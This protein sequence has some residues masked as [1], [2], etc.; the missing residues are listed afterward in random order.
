MYYLLGIGHIVIILILIS[1][2]LITIPVFAQ[3]DFDFRYQ[4]KETWERLGESHPTQLRGI[5]I[6]SNDDLYVIDSNKLRKLTT[7]NESLWTVTFEIGA[8]GELFLNQNDEII[9][10]VYR[11]EVNE[12]R[13]YS[14]SGELIK[15]WNV[16]EF[17]L[18]PNTSN[19]L[20]VDKNENIYVNEWVPIQSDIT[21]IIGN[22][23]KFDSSGNLLKTYENM[24]LL[25]LIDDKGN[26]YTTEP[27]KIIKHDPNG[28]KIIE[29]GKQKFRGGVGTFFQQ[30]ETIIVDANGIIFATGGQ[31]GPINIIDEEG[32]FSGIGG[33]GLL[34]GKYGW[35]RG[36]AL[37]SEN[38]AYVTDYSREKILVYEKIPLEKIPQ[39][40]LEPEQIVCPQGFEP[41]NGKC[42]DKPVIL[43]D[44]NMDNP[45]LARK[46][47]DWVRN[48]FIWYAEERISED[49]L[50]NAIQFLLDQGILKN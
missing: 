20:Y 29:Y 31:Y 50:L 42:P 26:F 11:K 27:G 35:P 6:D 34:E 4:Y 33:Y 5:V 18:T 47:P 15:T 39:D 17:D 41:V 19:Y 38:T 3:S 16:N 46:I 21:N 45:E 2:P 24:G 25:M 40:E 14:Q 48:I 7:D 8:S 30:A 9:V 44:P 37:D 28:N 36:I 12:L 49:E 22:L 13:K 10:P 1:V 32:N 23:K 43:P